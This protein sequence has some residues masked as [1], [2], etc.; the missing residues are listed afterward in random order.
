MLLSKFVQLVKHKSLLAA[1]RAS[2]GFFIRRIGLGRYAV[3]KRRRNLSKL[4]DATYNSTVAYGPFA[5]LRLGPLSWWGVTDRGS[6]LL[7]IYEQELL[8][9]IHTLAGRHDFLIDLGAADGYYAIGCQLADIV[10]HTICFELSDVGREAIARNAEIN[11]VHNNIE[12]RGTAGKNFFLDIPEH[13]KSSSLVL[14][15][16]EGAEFDVFD[17]NAFN[18]FRNS[19]IFIEIHE[20]FFSDG[21]QRLEKMVEDSRKTHVYSEITTSGRDLSSFPELALFSDTDRWLICSEGRSRL[22]RWLR[23]DPLE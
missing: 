6:M 20:W 19:T 1:L 13:A 23:F 4:I 8:R 10:K 12:I 11:G 3:D 21:V 18:E 5:G 2:G 15:D 9:S 17:A 7:G 16:I 22:M 14:V